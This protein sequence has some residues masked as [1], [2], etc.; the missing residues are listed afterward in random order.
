MRAA[1]TTDPGY[2]KHHNTN[3]NNHICVELLKVSKLLQQ[4]LP[5]SIATDV[6]INIKASL[7]DQFLDFFVSTYILRCKL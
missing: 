1:V 6:D 4:L 7:P 3:K 2:F 5:K